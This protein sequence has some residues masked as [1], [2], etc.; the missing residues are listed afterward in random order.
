[1]FKFP[2]QI[3]LSVVNIEV[4][5]HRLTVVVIRVKLVSKNFFVTN[6]K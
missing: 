6:L 2:D 1:M 5:S 3:V 4:V